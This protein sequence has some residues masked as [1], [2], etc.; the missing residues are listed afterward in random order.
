M[1]ELK[2]FRHLYGSDQDY[3]NVI[4][5][6][7]SVKQIRGWRKQNYN[8]LIDVLAGHN[9]L[10]EYYFLDRERFIVYVY[11]KTRRIIRYWRYYILERDY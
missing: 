8:S 11:D 3:F 9:L 7:T 4:K 6:D 5:T 10:G 2:L 1:Y